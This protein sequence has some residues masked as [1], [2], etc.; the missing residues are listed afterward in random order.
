MSAATGDRRLLVLAATSRDAI[1]TEQ[2]LSPLGVAATVCRSF[3]DL[4]REVEVGAGAVLVAE[5][6]MPPAHTAA[7]HRVLTNQP[8][9]SDLPILVLT[10]PGADSAAS[11]DAV[12]ML[13]NV[14]LLERPI[15]VATLVT[16]VL[17][18]LR[19]RERQYQIRDHLSQRIANEASLREV[20]RRKDEF[21]AT[22]G[23]ELRNPLA[24]LQTAV[25]LL[26]AA[27]STD[28]VVTRVAPVMDRQISHLV[29]LVND[30]LEVSRITRGLIEVHREPVDLV[31]LVH[32]ALDTSLPM[33]DAA[34]HQVTVDVPKE[35]VTVLG[36]TVR[37]TQVFSNLLN[38]AAKYTHAGGHI[39]VRVWKDGDRAIVSV[40]DD[41]IG[42]ARDDLTS[43]FEMFT[44]VDRS[45]RLAQGGLGIGLTLVRSLVSMHGGAVHARSD[46]PGTGSEFIVSLPLHEGAARPADDVDIARQFPRR[47][48]L[49]VDDNSDAADTLA[50]LLGALGATVS[51]AYSGRTALEALDPFQPDAVILDV[52]MPEMDGYEVARRIRAT[53]RDRHLLLIALTGWG[54]ESD[55]SRSRAAGFDHHIVKPPDLARLR[56]LLVN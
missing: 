50:A 53:I 52:G 35:P 6:G 8:P 5:E 26:K 11:G 27:G 36:D 30:L 23:H 33:L 55:Q 19:A 45:N 56:E 2:V 22:L 25:Q 17:S 10:R 9:W 18:A 16:A 54:Q 3:D 13:G 7:F 31:F 47:R 37:L 21:L 40:R 42:I 51:V 28:P 49:I 38:N 12:R 39:A 41:G 15:R 29:R 48:I 43:V 4:L 1:T 46:G 20:D 14:T 44:Q 24:P 32:S 34:N